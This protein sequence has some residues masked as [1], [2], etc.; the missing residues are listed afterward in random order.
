MAENQKYY[1]L[2]LREDFF[3]T[4]EML[5]LESMPDGYL[6]S[7]ILLK[8][9]LRSLKSDGRLMYKNIIPY[10]PSVLAT[11]VRHPIGVVEKAL[12]VF[13]Q[14]G[15]IEVLDNGAI[16]MMD[17]QNMV[18][19][20]STNADRM[21]EYRRRIEEEKKSLSSIDCTNEITNV[22]TDVIT[23]VITNDAQMSKKCNDKSAPEI[24]IERE[25]EIRDREIGG[26][27]SPDGEA[28]SSPRSHVDYEEIQQ[29]YNQICTNLPKCKTL[30]E[31]RKKAIK[32][33]TSSGY[34]VEDFK[35]CFE[36]AQAS[37]FLCGG[38]DRN[39]NANFDWLIKD[40]NM[41]KV[42]DGNYSDNGNKQYKR[43]KPSA[44]SQM[45]TYRPPEE[46]ARLEEW[47][48]AREE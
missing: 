15:L 12:K 16:Y 17:I 46:A 4:D 39:W 38:N 37:R 43:V 34:T 32:A 27:S 36:M 30:S 31:S 26:T 24:E 8:L 7:N 42:L 18:G 19:K 1:Y 48:R 28:P 45:T 6:Y 41:A 44:R 11:L 5:L 35:K 14:L 9:Y 25:I 47:I 20:S 13:Q 23:N 21:R 22:T 40:A 3:D 2:K 29:L 10:T 33:R